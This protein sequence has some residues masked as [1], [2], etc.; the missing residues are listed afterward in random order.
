MQYLIFY[1]DQSQGLESS[2]LLFSIRTVHTP[3][4]KK[5]VIWSVPET[6]YF[7]TD[8]AVKYQGNYHWG[9]LRTV[10]LGQDS[11]DYVVSTSSFINDVVQHLPISTFFKQECHDY[12]VDLQI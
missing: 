6:T 2:I 9:G 10:R 7:H 12:A 1:L 3:Q 11:T 8:Y 4:A 5:N